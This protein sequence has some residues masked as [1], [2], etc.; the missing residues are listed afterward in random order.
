MGKNELQVENRGSEGGQSTDMMNNSHLL[1][2][3]AAAA[4]AAAGMCGFPHG[5]GRQFG[6]G[7]LSSG[8]KS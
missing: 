5:A 4:A 2:F 6:E 1:C 8:D 3:W 7:Q